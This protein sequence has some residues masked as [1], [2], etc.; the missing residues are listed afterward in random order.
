[1]AQREGLKRGWLTYAELRQLLPSF[2]L[3]KFLIN[4]VAVMAV[5]YAASVMTIAS[6]FFL[7]SQI[8][9]TILHRPTINASSSAAEN[10]STSNISSNGT[11]IVN[12]TS[13]LNTNGEIILPATRR[14]REQNATVTTVML[15]NGTC[16]NLNV[17]T[18]LLNL[19][20]QYQEEA[21]QE[22]LLRRNS[23]N[24]FSYSNLITTT[25]TVCTAQQ[26]GKK[27]QIAQ[28]HTFKDEYSDESNYSNS[29]LTKPIYEE[30]IQ[31]LIYEFGNLTNSKFWNLLA[32][33][34][35]NVFM[36]LPFMWL[37]FM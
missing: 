3:A 26:T 12:G 14:S 35:M 13:V 34:Q 25:T 7:V 31:N 19:E 17:E 36:R 23:E 27:S 29:K 28:W 30:Y 1:M 11:Q 8:P 10:A 21:E 33:R 37:K 20:K 24:H 5:S 16:S 4:S 32:E 6:A 2:T 15:H 18:E 9:G 22:N